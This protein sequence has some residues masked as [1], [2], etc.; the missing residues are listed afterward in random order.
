MAWKAAR[1]RG[2]AGADQNASSTLC[3]ASTTGAAGALGAHVGRDVRPVGGDRVGV[4]V[5]VAQR[6]VGERVRRG[7]RVAPDRGPE[8]ERDAARGARPRR[9]PGARRGPRAPR[10]PPGSARTRRGAHAALRRAQHGERQRRVA[11]DR[12]AVAHVAADQREHDVLLLVQRRERADAEGRRVVGHE[13]DRPRVAAHRSASSYACTVARPQRSHVNAASTVAR[14]AGRA[15]AASRARPTSCV[16]LRGERLRVRRAAR[17][18]GPGPRAAI[19]SGPGSPRQPI[20]GTA[21]AI[22]ST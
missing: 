16:D 3:G 4:A 17:A 21:P 8:H 12:A 5:E 19:S 22:A 6:Q 1:R 15:P 11:L 9:R 14:A 10:P 18:G 13:E 7:A 20:A 2:S